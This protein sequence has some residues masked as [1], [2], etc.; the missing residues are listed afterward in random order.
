MQFIKSDAE[1]HFMFSS[2]DFITLRVLINFFEFG[3]QDY[4][5][6]KHYRCNSFVF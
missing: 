4:V 1:F 3:M 5:I 6:K 2:L